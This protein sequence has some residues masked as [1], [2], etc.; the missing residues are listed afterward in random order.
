MTDMMDDGQGIG[1]PKRNDIERLVG[2]RSALIGMI[3]LRPL[4]GSPR[5]DQR[6]GVEAIYELALRE[7]KMLEDAGFDGVIVE[8]GGDVPFLP[9]D[10]VGKETVAALSVPT[11]LLHGALRVPVGV[12]CL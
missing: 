2:R 4:P 5:Y 8:N 3:H 7:G 6:G 12:N 10:E 9:P 1:R 11:R